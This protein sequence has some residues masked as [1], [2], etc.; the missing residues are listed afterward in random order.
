MGAYHAANAVF[1]HPDLFDGLVAMSG[2][3]GVST[4]I[5]DYVD[6]RVYYNSPLLYLPGLDDP[7]Y[8]ERL[9]EARLAIVVGQG[10]WEDDMLNDTRALE[11]ILVAKGIP[12]IVDYWG[13][14]VNHDWPWWRQMLPHYLDRLGV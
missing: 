4:F 13:Q 5:G 6:D 10:A 8:L 9:R 2:L 11:A 1:R 7:W 3:Y 14:D 12:A